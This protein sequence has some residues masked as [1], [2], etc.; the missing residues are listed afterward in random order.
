MTPLPIERD[1]V[2]VRLNGIQAELRELDDLMR[3]SRS[4]FVTGPQ[5]KLAAYHLHRILE[6][7]FNIANHILARLPGG[8]ASTYK[9]MAIGLGTHG[10]V[11]KL[12][13]N[14]TLVKMAGYRN[15]L[16]HFYSEITLGELFTV[17][18]QGRADIDRF[19]RA[20]RALLQH[21]RKFGL[22]VI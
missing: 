13:A 14:K 3:V 16:V 10:I 17:V 21:P 11:P 1:T 15:R 19:C 4:A 22:T 18:R 5:Y 8:A 6:G 9:E 2:V 7:V 12:F 20:V